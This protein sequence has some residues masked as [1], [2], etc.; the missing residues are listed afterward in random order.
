MCG[1][2]RVAATCHATT[3]A[4][5]TEPCPAPP[6]HANDRSLPPDA[7]QVLQSGTA[8][9]L[10]LCCGLYFGGFFSVDPALP[11]LFREQ[12]ENPGT[13]ASGSLSQAGDW[14]PWCLGPGSTWVNGDASLGSPADPRHWPHMS[15][16]RTVKITSVTGS[17]STLPLTRQWQC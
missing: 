16:H 17:C 6:G 2:G 14:L 11:P 4:G 8:C 13:G 10:S 12:Q 9:S 15:L 5:G 1:Q 3:L 7:C